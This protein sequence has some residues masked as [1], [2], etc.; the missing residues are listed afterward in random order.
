MYSREYAEYIIK[1]QFDEKYQDVA[2]KIISLVNDEGMLKMTTSQI[3]KKVNCVES[4][5]IEVIEIMKTHKNPLVKLKKNIYV[6][7]YPEKDLQYVNHLRKALSNLGM[8]AD[9]FWE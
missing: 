3:S 6:F 4:E 7:D 8:L 1:E 5:I 2:N 9:D